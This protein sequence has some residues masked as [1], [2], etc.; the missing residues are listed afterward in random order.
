VQE[1]VHVVGLSI[2]SGSHLAVVPE[3]V[4]GLR[5][6]G[7]ADVPVVVGGIVPPQ[8]AALL[9]ERGVAR[10]FTPKDYELTGIMN[11]IVDVV[12]EANGIPT[13]VT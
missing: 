12:R 6:A 10:V 3:V 1:G 4:D 2:L 7:A 11:A 9:R 13:E 5:A 8:D